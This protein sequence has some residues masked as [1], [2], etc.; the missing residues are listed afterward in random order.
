MCSGHETALQ[1]ERRAHKGCAT[2]AHGGV[3][4]SCLGYVR[5]RDDHKSA[6]NVMEIATVN[7]N[8][9]LPIRRARRKPMTNP[10]YF[11]SPSFRKAVQRGVPENNCHVPRVFS[12]HLYLCLFFIRQHSVAL[13]HVIGTTQPPRIETWMSCTYPCVDK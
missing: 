1:R 4:P 3:N 2:C 8:L 10:A 11:Q 6:G 9:N 5:M 12:L 7:G 13:N